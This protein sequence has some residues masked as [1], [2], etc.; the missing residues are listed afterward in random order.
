MDVVEMSYST[1]I[2]AARTTP[3]LLRDA[4]ANAWPNLRIVDEAAGLQNLEE[5]F[6]WS[7]SRNEAKAFYQDGEWAVLFDPEMTM[8]GDAEPL[9][10]LS[11]SL[12]KVFVGTT[13]GTSGFAEIIVLDGGREIRRITYVDEELTESGEPLPEEAGLDVADFYMA[14]NEEIAARLGIRSFWGEDIRPP[15]LA[16]DFR[17]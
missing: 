15:I 8:C 4:V 14:A 3:Q 17:E 6:E 5:F 11:K 12:G 1:S 7:R 10:S 9:A 13:Q 2:I 16:V